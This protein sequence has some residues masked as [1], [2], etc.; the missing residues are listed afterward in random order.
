MVRSPRISPL[1][2]P[3]RFTLRLLNAI[4]GENMSSRLF[5]VVREDRGLAYSIYSTPSFFADTGDLVVSAGLDT[6]NLLKTLRLV[7]RELRQDVAHHPQD[8][9]VVAVPGEASAPRDRRGAEHGAAVSS[10]EVDD[11]GSHERALAAGHSRVRED[12]VLVDDVVVDAALDRA[13][14]QDEPVA[15]R[16]PSGAVAGLTAANSPN[17]LRSHSVCHMR[18]TALGNVTNDDFTTA[19]APL[20]AFNSTLKAFAEK[21]F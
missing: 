10:R 9:V 14:E 11:V 6:D 12:D 5:Q 4:L 16:A 21:Y 20:Q 2:G 13:R 15:R 1:C 18:G 8:V 7:L 3:V 17:N 19:A